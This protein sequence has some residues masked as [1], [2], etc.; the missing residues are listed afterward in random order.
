MKNKITIMF[1]MFLIFFSG[2]EALAQLDRSIRPKAG[3]APEI[4]IGEH[5][6]FTLDNGLKVIVVENHKIPQIS[7]QL[8]VDVDPV[9]EEDAVGYVSMT[10]NLMRSGT[11]NKTKQEIDEQ[12]DFI[13]GN[14]STYGN[15]I[16]ASSLTKHSDELLKL[17][18]DVLMNPI[19]PEDELEKNKK[20]TISGLAA[21]KTRP[22]SIASRVAQRIRYGDN[23]PYGEIQT[24]EKVDNITRDHCV[25][26]YN[27]Y[28]KPNTSYLVIVGD[29]N[30]KEAKEK[31]EKHFGS[32]KKGEVPS[33]EYKVPEAPEK[34]KV[35]L[36]HQDGAVQSVINV[37]Y[38]LKLTP[39]HEDVIPVRLTNDILGGGVFSGRLMQNLREDKGYTYG[40]RSTISTDELVGYFNASAEVGTDVTPDAVNQFLIEM[41]RM[42]DEKVSEEHLNLVK[43][44][45]TGSFA[46]SLE[47]PQTIASFALNTERYKLPK[48]YYA[49]YLKNLNAVSVNQ[50]Q[51]MALKYILPE[52]SYILVVG[53]KEKLMEELKEYTADGEV[54]LLDDYGNQ[55]KEKTTKKLP[56]GITAQ[57]IIDQY[58]EAIG[59][60]EKLQAVKDITIKASTVMNG[61]EINQIT[62]R[63]APNKYAM[64]MS[65]NANVLMEQKFDGE[66][67]KMKSFQGEQEIKG[68]DLEN[69]KIEAAINTELKYDNLGIKI[70]LTGIETVKDKNS[71]KLKVQLPTGKTT[72]DFYDVSSGLKIMSKQNINTPQGEMTQTQTFSDYQE[73]DGIL[74]PT[75]IKISGIQNMEL[76]VNTVEIN[77]D[78]TDDLF[79]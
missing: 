62:Y 78:L 52:H 1:T 75:L 66:V 72:Y 31:A 71:Y 47:R 58:I 56:E 7:Y 24:E 43:N 49:N 61:M 76:K 20:R 28:Y 13:G 79:Q 35:V 77:T 38:P 39:A 50:V 2:I 41:R 25:N 44:V 69:L 32:W 54:L 40:A 16:Y 5:Q 68:D 59:G 18:S 55:L 10:G 74:Y 73:F 60:K 26:Y 37:T 23:H 6:S 48:D 36:V 65:M 11:K 34:T 15:G 14:L 64:K 8:S 51:E 17:M 45:R 42:R 3:P 30:L 33:H 19:F 46:R 57:K 67:G 53:D 21:S 4:T 12:I 22:S 9:M 27:T 70:T 29:I 63:K